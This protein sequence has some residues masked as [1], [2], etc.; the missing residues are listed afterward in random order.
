MKA[1]VCLAKDVKNSFFLASQIY[2]LL[3][4]L[5]LLSSSFVLFCLFFLFSF[6]F[7]LNNTSYILGCP[8]SLYDVPYIFSKPM[9]FKDP[10]SLWASLS[11]PP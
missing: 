10:A 6:L 7:S 5:L 8:H 11:L 3:S 2:S 4:Y 1:S 9:A